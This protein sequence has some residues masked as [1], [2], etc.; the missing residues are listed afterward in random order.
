MVISI[1]VIGGSGGAVVY[2]DEIMDF[3]Q[4]DPEYVLID[5]DTDKTILTILLTCSGVRGMGVSPLII[6]YLGDITELKFSFFLVPI[7]FF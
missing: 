1:L 4:G 5:F 6:G 2:G 3:I 7:Y